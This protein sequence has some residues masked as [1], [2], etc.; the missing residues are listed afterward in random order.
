MKYM[1]RE[2]K[3]LWKMFAVFVVMELL[4]TALGLLLIFSASDSAAIMIAAAVILPG[5][6]WLNYVAARRSMS[7][8]VKSDSLSRRLQIA[9]QEN[10]E[11]STDD[12]PH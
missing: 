12:L 6:I 5:A 7:L 2:I 8:Q 3:N 11:R 1:M 10:M 4:I 9:D